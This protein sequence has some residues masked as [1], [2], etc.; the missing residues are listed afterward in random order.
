MDLEYPA[1]FKTAL[2]PLAGY[3]HYADSDMVGS[4][5]GYYIVAARR[6]YDF[7]DASGVA[8]GLVRITRNP[9]GAEPSSSTTHSSC[10]RRGSP[11]PS[12]W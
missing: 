4:P 12:V 10:F 7:H 6:S 8:R 3:T 5:G 1:G 2:P 11:M 9:L